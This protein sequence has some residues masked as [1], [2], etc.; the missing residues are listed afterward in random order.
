MGPQELKC[1]LDP[2]NDLPSTH[3]Q[4]STST[5]VENQIQSQNSQGESIL[6]STQASTSTAS[7]Q[8]LTS[9]GVHTHG[10]RSQEPAQR[11]QALHDLYAEKFRLLHQLQSKLLSLE[12]SNERQYLPSMAAHTQSVASMPIINESHLM[13]DAQSIIKRHIHLLSKYNEIRDIG[14]GLI[15][16]VAENRRVRVQEC[17][18]EFGITDKD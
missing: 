13:K 12:D 18:E 5:R 9:R 8:S 6:P 2:H 11:S 10:H 3:T 14:Q 4:D 17:Q 7:R 16:M 15:G 1:G